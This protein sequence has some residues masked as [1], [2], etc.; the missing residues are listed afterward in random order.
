MLHK[1]VDEFNVVLLIL[2][3]RDPARCRNRLVGRR[4]VVQARSGGKAS[5]C[6]C[7]TK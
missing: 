6:L 3:A 7:S 1:V 5:P 4:V 2:N